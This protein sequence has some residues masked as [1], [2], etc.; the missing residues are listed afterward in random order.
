MNEKRRE[1]IVREIEYWKRSRLLPEH[2]CDY[3]LAL[4]TEGEVT[5]SAAPS[6]KRWATVFFLLFICLLLPAGVLVIYFTELSFVL[7]MLL[8]AFFVGICLMAIWR[9]RKEALVHLPLISG[10]FLLFLATVRLSDY[11]FSGSKAVLSLVI[12]LN[13]FLWIVIGMRFRFLYLTISGVLG[14]LLLTG[15]FFF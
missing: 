15:S 2:Y 12:F 9:W 10:A 4:Y 5:P 6:R 1:I 14:L 3:L 13:C 7:Q 8:L 11:Y